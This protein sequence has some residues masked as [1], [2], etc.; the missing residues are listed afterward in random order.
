MKKQNNKIF[1]EKI[2]P[3][4]DNIDKIDSQILSLLARRHDQVLKVVNLKKEHNIPVYHP[5]REEDLI[6]RLRTQAKKADLDPDFLEELYR[7]ILR[8]S[9]VKQTDQMEIKGILPNGRVLIIGG[10]GQMGSFF[11]SL[12]IK[13]G[14]EVRILGKSD[15]SMAEQ[16]C[17]DI[18]LALIS[19][20]IE[21]TCDIIE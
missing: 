4:R 20:P 10:K 3:L 13:S 7:T 2:I 12:F 5:A 15:W 18:D 16:L 9:R 21:Q 8:H 14:Y 6:Y 19:V 1:H 11:A 17:Q